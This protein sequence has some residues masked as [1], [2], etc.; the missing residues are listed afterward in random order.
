[1]VTEQ[2]IVQT[3]EPTLADVLAEMKADRESRVKLENRVGWIQRQL[4][5]TPQGQQPDPVLRAELADVKEQLAE[6]TDARIA[7]LDDDQ[8]VEVYKARAQKAEKRAQEAGKVSRW[9]ETV[10]EA[11]L[12]TYFQG[13]G[14]E[15]IERLC[16]AGGINLTPEMVVHIDKTIPL[17]INPYTK[18]VDPTE[19][20]SLT[21][22]YLLEQ[23]KAQQN[24]AETPAEM[25]GKVLGDGAGAGGGAGS[26]AKPDWLDPNLSFDDMWA[27]D[28]KP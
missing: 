17:T 28:R 15:H 1:M 7:D 9:P 20:Y 21:D 14:M 19:F 3:A 12:N 18:Q 13:P 4:E 23:G 24:K 10:L 25:A 16:Q 11:T 22:A 8:K 5:H 26:K 6:L 2:T 27:Y